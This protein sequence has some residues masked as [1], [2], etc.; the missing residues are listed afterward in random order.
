MRRLIH[1][2][3]P[4]RVRDSELREWKARNYAAPSP[5]HIKRSVLLRVG[6]PAGTWVETGTYLGETTAF[7]A[8]Q[9]RQVYSIEPEAALHARAQ[10]LFAGRNNVEIIR[11]TSEDVFPELM[12][13]LSGDVS[14]WLDGHYSAGMTFKGDKD[15]PIKEEL[16]AIAQALP[17]LGR[18]AVMVDDVRCFEPTCPDF[19]H[20]PPR[21]YLV[22]WADR[23][24]LG[25][26]IEHDIFVARRDEPTASRVAE[27]G[28]RRGG[29]I[30]PAG[31]HRRETG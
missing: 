5:P 7:L 24:G 16:A 14:F 2:L 1:T 28:L 10:A 25:W 30:Q 29:E 6:I 21:S 13:R 27:P 22:E 12:P 18:V 31:G 9:A 23:L 20:Y 26:H 19:S 4:S 8:G 11:G 17:R 3:F 15:T